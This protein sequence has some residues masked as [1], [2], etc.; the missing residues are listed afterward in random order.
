MS[1]PP[2][3]RTR[4]LVRSG[5]AI[6]GLLALQSTT[7]AAEV[8]AQT[9]SPQRSA[10]S[11]VAASTSPVPA[12]SPAQTV[13]AA[14]SSHMQPT[15]PAATAVS[16]TRHVPAP[17]PSACAAYGAAAA[18]SSRAAYA[19]SRFARSCL[20]E[21][22]PAAAT[23]IPVHAA[24]ASPATPSASAA[25]QEHQ[26]PALSSI[27]AMTTPAP[28]AAATITSYGANASEPSDAPQLSEAD[29][30]QVDEPNPF[31]SRFAGRTVRKQQQASQAAAHD[32]AADDRQPSAQPQ[33]VGS[34]T[35]NGVGSPFADR[36]LV[37]QQ[38]PPQATPAPLPTPE[39]AGVKASG[40]RP[41]RASV[42]LQILPPT[43]QSIPSTVDMIPSTGSPSAAVLALGLVLLGGVGLWLRRLGAQRT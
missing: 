10:S 23:A 6:A 16:N 15:V 38:E 32:L 14:S 21:S 3:R 1:D 20:A 7:M 8:W 13:V 17:A 37:S 4:M 5:V 36:S 33:V 24:T 35:S 9:A 11:V 41:D 43:D 22:P 2:T 28:A 40:A 19:E 42:G 18:G 30:G 27:V 29:P 34:S 25:T 39:V 12:L 31:D 26:A